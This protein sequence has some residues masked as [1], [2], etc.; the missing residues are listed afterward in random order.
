MIIKDILAP[1][2]AGVC[3]GLFK[4]AKVHTGIHRQYASWKNHVYLIKCITW[5][6]NTYLKHPKK[7]LHDHLTF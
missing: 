1:G 6:K 2:D 5:L 3:R 7:V 4:N